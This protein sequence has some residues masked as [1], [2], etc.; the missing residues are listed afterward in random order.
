M[1]NSPKKALEL[2]HEYVQHR[3]AEVFAFIFFVTLL[4]SP[5]DSFKELSID[6]KNYADL[7]NEGL[8]LLIAGLSLIYALVQAH[9][10]RKAQKLF[11]MSVRGL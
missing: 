1:I 7:I 9:H 6:G 5:I 10:A 11:F 4:A 3:L 2:H 8:T